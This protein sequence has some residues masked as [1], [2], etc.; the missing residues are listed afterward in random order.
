MPIILGVYVFISG[1]FAV[2]FNWIYANLHG[3]ISWLFFG[4]I[5]AT[6]QGLLWPIYLIT[7]YKIF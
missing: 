7:G 2:Y 4:E 5:I 3:F 1:L 6:I